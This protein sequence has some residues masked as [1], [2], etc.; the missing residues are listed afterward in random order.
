M[1]TP[2]V[3]TARMAS[4]KFNGIDIA[5]NEIPADLDT[6]SILERA[7]S[8]RPAGMGEFFPRDRDVS[9][10]QP[11]KL[12]PRASSPTGSVFSSFSSSRRHVSRRFSAGG[13]ARRS[14]TEVTEQLTEQA[15]SEFFALM[16]LMSSISRRSTSLR[17]VWTKLIS[18][19]DSYQA[20]MDRMYETIDEYSQIIERKEREEHNH[21]H[22]HEEGKK[23]VTKLRLELAAVVASVAEYKRKLVDR[24][25]ERDN[26]RRELHEYKETV[27]R[28]REEH[29]HTKTTLAETQ[30]KLAACEDERDHARGDASK[31]HGDL[32]ILH[33]K[34][35]ELQSHHTEVT[36]KY[37]SSHVELLSARQTVSSLKKE[38][39]AWLLEASEF[40]ERLRRSNHKQHELTRKLEETTEKYEKSAREVHKLKESSSRL[41]YEREELHQKVEELKR[42]LEETHGRWEDAEDRCGKWKLKWEHC[43]REIVTVRDE[44]KVV[45]TEKTKLVE[46]V[47]KT[48]EEIRLLVI[49]K[50]RLAKD[51]HHAC[52]QAEEHRRR[53]IVLQESLR[54]A[55]SSLK[56]K[57]EQYLSLTERFERVE[58][59]RDDLRHRCGDATVELE[60]LQASS[61]ALA[62]ELAIMVEKHESVTKRLH[63][64]EAS[65]QEVCETV[66]EY[67]TT[68]GGHAGEW[69]LELGTLRTMLR[70]A[71]DQKEK[72]ISAR[73][74]AVAS[75][76]QKRRELE[77][78]QEQVALHYHHQGRG[79][80]GGKTQVI[81]RTTHVTANGHAENSEEQGGTAI[82]Y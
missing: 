49:D 78:F 17:E 32:E 13:F 66:T 15:E 71:R 68:R 72:A 6:L 54:R 62:A 28:L 9:Q 24:D 16:E 2:T 53:I 45:E 25:H 80:V 51:H 65:Y 58:S 20:E 55:E 63:E 37:E 38:R 56:E 64:C 21:S 50:E 3:P 4:D 36:A 59:E 33:L 27:I 5:I 1:E 26:A 69:D 39:E 40:E 73:N 43:E 29:E 74:D 60:K 52:G 42:K 14:R 22:D 34:Y 70:E 76:E 10:H 75:L 8:P 67:E 79:V 57:T 77:R 35:A 7:R 47:T 46:T 19:R 23:E 82:I 18:E 61:I 30:L 31:H 12:L 81:T 11:K 48:R 41:E 44:L